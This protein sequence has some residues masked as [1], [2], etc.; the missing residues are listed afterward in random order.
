MAWSWISTQ[1]WSN[2]LIAMWPVSRF[3]LGAAKFFEAKVAQV[4]AGSKFEQEIRQEQEE[5]KK[6]EEE[7]R[8]RKAEF[9]ARAQS[10][11]G[12]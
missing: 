12:I 10:F 5:R 3:F 9:K 8:K 4:N 1:N 7:K 6:Q 11:E 2:K